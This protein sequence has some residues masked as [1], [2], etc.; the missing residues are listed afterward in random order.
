MLAIYLAASDETAVRFFIPTE[1]RGAY[2]SIRGSKN[3]RRRGVREIIISI[4]KGSLED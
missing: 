1:N 4:E 3:L 2:L